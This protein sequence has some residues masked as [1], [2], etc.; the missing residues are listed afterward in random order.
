M[1]KRQK[2]YEGNDNWHELKVLNGRQ[3]RYDVAAAPNASLLLLTLG[4]PEVV[5]Y[6]DNV[7]SKSTGNN[8]FLFESTIDDDQ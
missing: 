8:V 4:S 6:I 3:Q 1:T 5:V 7:Y 2:H